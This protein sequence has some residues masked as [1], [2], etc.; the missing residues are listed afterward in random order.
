[1]IR[2]LLLAL[3]LPSIA[4]ADTV[5]YVAYT[6]VY[7]PP[8]A[9]LS[10]AGGVQNPWGSCAVDA[11]PFTNYAYSATLG[12]AADV[13]GTVTLSA[14]IGSTASASKTVTLG[15]GY[16][17]AST[18]TLI[19][20]GTVSVPAGSS[21]ARSTTCSAARTALVTGD[22]L[23]VSVSLPAPGT[24]GSGKEMCASTGSGSYIST[25]I[26]GTNYGLG[27]V[28]NGICNGSSCGLTGT[29]GAWPTF[30][31]TCDCTVAGCTGLAITGPTLSGVN[32]SNG[33]GT[34]NWGSI[35]GAASYTLQR[36][37]G[38]I[39]GPGGLF[40]YLDSPGA[41]AFTYN[42]Y[43]T[44]SCAP[45]IGG[46]TLASKTSSTTSYPLTISVAGTAQPCIITN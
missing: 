16:R 28:C 21:G 42:V 3:L 26:G 5:L 45:A 4:L 6:Q 8:S 18:N 43:A 40:T 14:D 25:P 38:T 15:I 35:P 24:V 1:M 32:N 36:G 2:A 33:T 12:A 34:L 13:V 20:S 39:Y 11:T 29:S 17:R 10:T 44:G 22:R 31:A 7:V 19:C 41:G 23:Y 30:G 37:A 9:D 27:C 46:T